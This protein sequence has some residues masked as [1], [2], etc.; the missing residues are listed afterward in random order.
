MK[1]LKIIIFCCVAFFLTLSLNEAHARYVVS[2]STPMVFNDKE[3]R[4][5]EDLSHQASH[6]DILKKLDLF[7]FILKMR[8]I[9][10]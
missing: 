10:N 8:K 4:V 7:G 1:K 5:Y 6:E 3:V 9:K 2:A